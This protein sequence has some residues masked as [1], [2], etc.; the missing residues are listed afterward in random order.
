MK[1]AAV[2]R[3]ERE[4]VPER[5]VSTH[6]RPSKSKDPYSSKKPPSASA[7]V[8]SGARKTSVDIFSSSDLAVSDL[9]S[10]AA[11]V[12]LVRRGKV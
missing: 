10:A 7:K 12:K 11:I 9:P 3:T 2:L 8:A 6:G 5:R 4:K 1:V